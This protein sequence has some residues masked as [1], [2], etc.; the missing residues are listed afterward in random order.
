MHQ[1][2][3]TEYKFR[4]SSVPNRIMRWLFTAPLPILWL[5]LTDSGL[6]GTRYFAPRCTWPGEPVWAAKYSG[7]YYNI[8]N[9]VFFYSVSVI[10][11]LYGPSESEERLNTMSILTF[12]DCSSGA[13][14]LMLQWFRLRNGIN[15]IR[16]VAHWHVIQRHVPANYIAVTTKM[17][18]EIFVSTFIIGKRTG[19][20][21][22]LG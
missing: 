21:K 22:I 18:E 5:V 19:E 1:C 7:F 16:H 8:S 2:I 10:N 12:E 20:L 9:S 17:T 11:I 4:I 14:W 3:S 6:T 15:F 13:G